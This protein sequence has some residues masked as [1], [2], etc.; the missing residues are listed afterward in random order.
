M[1]NI[2]SILLLFGL[3]SGCS[4]DTRTPEEQ[5]QDRIEQGRLLA[6]QRDTSGMLEMTTEAFVGPRGMNRMALRQFLARF[7][8]IYKSPH[9]LVHTKSLSVHGSEGNVTLLVAVANVPLQDVN[10]ADVRARFLQLEFEFVLRDEDWQVSV[11]NWR[12]ASW[13][14]F[15]R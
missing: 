12:N 14:D 13:Q 2:I 1:K 3:L 6:E 15:V 10:L 11:A 9:V 4:S 7:F 5:L 8:L